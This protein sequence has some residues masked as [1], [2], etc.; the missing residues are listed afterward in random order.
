M[1]NLIIRADTAL[2][3]AKGQGGN[4]VKTASRPPRG[5]DA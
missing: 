3:L 2:Y 1:E 4:A 5:A